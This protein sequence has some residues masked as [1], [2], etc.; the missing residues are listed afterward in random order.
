MQ[1]LPHVN[2]RLFMKKTFSNFLGIIKSQHSENYF[3]GSIAVALTI[4]AM[5][6]AS[7]N[8]CLSVNVD[9]NSVGYITSNK[10]YDAAIVEVKEQVQDE[11]GLVIGDAYNQIEIVKAHKLFAEKM[12]TEELTKALSENVEFLAQ[13][14]VLNI[15]N[16]EAQFTLSNHTEGQKVLDTL[17]AENTV[18]SDNAIIKS[19]DFVEDVRLEDT[20]VRISQ[21]KSSDQ[22]LASIKQGKEAEKF[23]Q[24][25]EGE[26]LWLIA[27]NNDL[28]VEELKA[29]N[30][31]LTTERLQIGQELKLTKLVPLV[32]VAVTKEVTAEESIAFETKYVDSTKLLR[33]EQEITTK[34]QEGKKQVTYEIT[35]SNGVAI[36]K[37]V[38][39]EK[40]VAEPVQQVVTKGTSTLMVAS[41]RSGSGALSWPIKGKIN[42]PYGKRSRGFHT[43]IDIDANTGNPVAAAAG[44]KVV[45]AGWAGGYGY[46]VVIDHGNGLKTRYAHLS[47]VLVSSGET[48]LRGQVVGRAGSTGNSTGPHLHFEVLVNGNHKN[49]INYLN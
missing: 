45:S 7:L 36:E 3:K 40:V 43:G 27:R 14:T 48:V 32:S 35:E 19:V 26:S 18:S 12:N 5:T 23:H 34:G 13:G 30:P 29:L 44:G 8:T 37:T 16:G 31:Q 46:C 6:F 24:V 42:S 20:N 1:I 9:G 11:T 25:A 22:V 39:N 17:I 41:S 49:P 21:I 10:I 38:L 4:A 28:S 2:L 33:G 47:K 15:N